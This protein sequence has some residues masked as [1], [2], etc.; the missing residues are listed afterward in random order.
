MAVAGQLLLCSA[1][2]YE[3]T[4]SLVDFHE[5]LYGA[6]ASHWDLDAIIFNPIASIILELLMFSVVM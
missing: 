2:S 4:N 1:F 6:N 3:L 5:I